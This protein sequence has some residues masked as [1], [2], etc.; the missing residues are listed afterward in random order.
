MS[1]RPKRYQ[2]PHSSLP[3]RQR[4]RQNRSSRNTPPDTAS[5]HLITERYTPPAPRELPELRVQLAGWL[6]S[7]ARQFYL[8]MALI[9]RQQLPATDGG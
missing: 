1:N 6:S 7:D 9:G 4:S 8:A 5:P 2:R 3:P